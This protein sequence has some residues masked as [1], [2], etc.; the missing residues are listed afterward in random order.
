MNDFLIGLQFLTRIRFVSQSEWTPESFGRSVKYFPAVGAVLGLI[1][2]GAALL[3][4]N[5]AVALGVTLPP[6]ATAALFVALPILLTGGLHTDGFM[7]T[8]DGI[9]S[10]RSKEKM[11][12]IMKDSRVGANG[13]T[14]FALLLLCKWSLLLDLPPAHTAA[15]LFVMPVVSR[16]AMVMGITLFPYARPEGIGK[17]FAVYAGGRA[18]LIAMPLGVLFLLPCGMA[19]AASAAAVAIF[20]ILFCRYVTKILGGLTGDVYGALTELSEVLSLLVFV[21]AARL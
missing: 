14:A 21:A 17:A 9:F 16:M 18:L 4:Q 12:E 11:L 7:D 6:H 2:A 10:G 1:L 19:A 8:M 20:T 5:A 13:V 15:A 3:S